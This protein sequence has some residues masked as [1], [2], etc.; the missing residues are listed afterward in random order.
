M[1][2]Y[3]SY[4]SKTEYA[5][6]FQKLINRPSSFHITRLLFDKINIGTIKLM[7]SMGTLKS[8]KM[9]GFFK[10]LG[11]SLKE[12]AAKDI[13]YY[14]LAHHLASINNDDDYILFLEEYTSV[15]V[16]LRIASFLVEDVESKMKEKGTLSF[17]DF[18]ELCMNVPIDTLPIC[19]D[20][21]VDKKWITSFEKIS[22]R[23]VLEEKYKSQKEQNNNTEK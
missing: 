7:I 3:W 18:A 21:F 23:E 1:D 2:T 19:L 15:F 8:D 17:N 13:Q 16:Q 22:L 10:E 11:S 4:L 5:I 12:L 14:D 9:L 20:I 6:L